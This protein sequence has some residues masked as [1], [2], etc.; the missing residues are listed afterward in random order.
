M[1]ILIFDKIVT[2][3]NMEFLHHLYMGGVK[4]TNDNYIVAIPKSF[5]K[6]KDKLKWPIS[7]NIQ[8]YYLPEHICKE[9]NDIKNLFAD[10]KI[11]NKLVREYKIDS[12]IFV[13]WISP[14]VYWFLPLSVHISGITYVIYL[15]LWENL[16][17]VSKVKWVIKE[18]VLALNPRVRRNYIQNDAVA[19][20]YL[21]RLYHTNKYLF[22]PDPLFFPK[23]TPK[24]VRNELNIHDDKKIILFFGN[25]SERKGIFDVLESLFF[26]S[27]QETSHFHFVF[28]GRVPDGVNDRFYTLFNKIKE[29]VQITLMDRFC[30]YEEIND[31]CYT[32]DMLLAPYKD[33][34]QSSGVIGYAAH[35]RKPVIAPNKGL[36]GKLVKRYE[37]GL[38]VDDLN[39]P[40]LYQA[41]FEYSKSG[42][43]A[44]IYEKDNSIEEFT[45][46][47]LEHF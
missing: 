9:R 5:N 35:Y 3:H 46:I 25:L 27:P 36:L 47:M 1:N 44:E 38:V 12:I 30:T 24:N 33:T 20:Q 16:S 21:N 6:E 32:C 23:Y 39:P 26:L 31:L 19:A 37:L 8:F 29:K 45:N 43:R 4:R 42:T 41:Y 14:F 34:T 18:L 15:Y 17:V 22:L 11:L 40:K 28:A 13:N 10:I 7:D 2:G